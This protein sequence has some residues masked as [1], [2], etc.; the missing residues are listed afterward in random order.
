MDSHPS[1]FP[2]PVEKKSYFAKI[3]EKKDQKETNNK[4]DKKLHRL[5]RL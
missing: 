5:T 1:N 4:D 3:R 2:L